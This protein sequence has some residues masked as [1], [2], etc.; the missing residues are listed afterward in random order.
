MALI[1][2]ILL[3]LASI[4]FTIVLLIGA[5]TSF[6]NDEFD[7]ETMESKACIEVKIKEAHVAQ[8]DRAPD[9]GSFMDH[10]VVVRKFT[11]TY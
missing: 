2:R 9:Y 7:T 6:A 11:N 8:L 4:V 3:F 5:T 1:I 10:F